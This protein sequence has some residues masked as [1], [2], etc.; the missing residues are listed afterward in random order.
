MTSTSQDV[1]PSVAWSGTAEPPRGSEPLARH[2][3][4]RLV[5][6]RC[7]LCGDDDAEPV[8]VGEDFERNTSPETFLAVCCRQCGL[9]YLN[10][11]PAIAEGDQI[12]SAAP[13]STLRESRS[14][15]WDSGRAGN[16]E[17]IRFCR[18]LPPAGRLIDLGPG[19]GGRVEFLRRHLGAE[20]QLDQAHPGPGPGLE[21]PAG[22]YDAMLAIDVLEQKENPLLT[23]S[24]MKQLLRIGGK[25]LIATPNTDST[26]CQLF[27]GRH[28]SGYDF[29]RHRNLF[30]AEVLAR[31]A[32][33]VG[34]EVT[35]LQTIAAPAIWVQSLRYVLADWGAPAWLRAGFDRT[36]RVTLAISAAMESIQQRR[37]RGGIVVATLHRSAA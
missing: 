17:L 29:P 1:S 27:R 34:L 28:W 12:S 23:L 6:S 30:D 7:F 8:A 5:P 31:S 14:I 33:R 37:G 15:P 25:L 18:L 4:L 21:F 3:L 10:P 9:V 26:V 11:W 16:R 2:K 24:A 36:R 32:E 35:S 19:A 22:A 13:G 20:W